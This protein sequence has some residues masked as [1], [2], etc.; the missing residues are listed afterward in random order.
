MPPTPREGNKKRICSETSLVFHTLYI[1][2]FNTDY[3]NKLDLLYQVQIFIRELD[4]D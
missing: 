4:F 1:Q 2:M 3:S